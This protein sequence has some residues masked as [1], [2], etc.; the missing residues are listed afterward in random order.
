[1][2]P[3]LDG[4]KRS[5]CRVSCEGCSGCGE[6]YCEEGGEDEQIGPEEYLRLKKKPVK[7]NI[8]A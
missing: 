4:C 6:G 3:S 8:W 7:A 5:V 1:M 2:R